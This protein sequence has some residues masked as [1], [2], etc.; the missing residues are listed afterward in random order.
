[1][2]LASV[3]AAIYLALRS[4]TLVFL[5]WFFLAIVVLSHGFTTTIVFERLCIDVLAKYR[6]PFMFTRIRIAGICRYLLL[7]K[8]QR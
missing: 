5:V 3:F 1:M 6:L 4:F 2:T 7:L 8:S